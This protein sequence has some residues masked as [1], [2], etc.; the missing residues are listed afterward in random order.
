MAGGFKQFY[1]TQICAHDDFGSV[2]GRKRGYAVAFRN[3]ADFTWPIPQK[4]RLAWLYTTIIKGHAVT[5]AN[6]LASL[7][8]FGWFLIDLF[9]FS[10]CK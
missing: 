6:F 8:Q 9:R 10:K 3:D 5:G 4:A 1:E 7:K 2:A